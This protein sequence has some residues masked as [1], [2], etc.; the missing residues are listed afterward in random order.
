MSR[1]TTSIRVALLAAAVAAPLGA[2]SSGA[3]PARS[4][5]PA[6][7]GQPQIT[8]AE[9]R[10]FATSERRRFFEENMALDAKSAA[11]FWEIYAKFEAERGTL[12]DRRLKLLEQYAKEYTKLT[13]ATA[14]T[15]SQQMGQNAAD[16]LAIRRKYAEQIGKVA[17]G[18]VAAR[19]MMLDD[20]SSSAAKL[21]LL[22]E[23][24][25]PGLQRAASQPPRP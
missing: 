11:P 20:A 3:A 5:Q 13:D 6:Q 7:A 17:G 9:L 16:E 2:Q 21:V 10:Y 14:L 1:L 12:F 18:A 24:P 25:L 19:F 23:I 8:P 15:M 4:M 22:S